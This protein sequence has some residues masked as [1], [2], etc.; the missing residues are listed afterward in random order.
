VISVD[1]LFIVGKGNQLALNRV[2]AVEFGPEAIA[3]VARSHRNNGVTA[4]VREIDDYPPTSAGEISVCLRSRNH[5]LSAFVQPRPFYTTYHVATLRPRTKMS[6]QEKLWWCL[7]IR[8]NRFRFNFGRQA[9]RTIG[10]LLLP[11]NVPP[12]VR[13]VE[14]PTHTRTSAGTY[15]GIDTASWRPFRL[16]DLFEFHFGKYVSR[17]ELPPGETPLVSAS[18]WNNGISAMVGVDPD[19]Q[20][21][22]ITLANNGSVGAAF[23]QPRPFVATKD[24]TILVPK[25]PLGP[26]L[27]P[28]EALFICTMLRKESTRFSYARKWTGGRMAESTILLPVSSGQP[29]RV[30][31]ARVMRGLRLGWVLEQPN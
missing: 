7:C 20:G 14:V 5:A 30:E 6:T 3:Y 24:V 4:W 19:W 11:P 8:A 25:E 16:S 10:S 27:S 15:S 29:D 13:A 2:E 26:T 9:N 22:Q 12:W 31:M 23:Y 18:A 28:P 21:S 1:S 17:R